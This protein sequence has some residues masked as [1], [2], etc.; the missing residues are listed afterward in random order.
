MLRPYQQKALD[1]IEGF[2]HF[3]DGREACLVACTSWG[4]SYIIAKLCEDYE[5]VV[6]LTNIT[7]LIYQTSDLLD[8]HGIAHSLLKANLKKEPKQESDNVILAMQQTLASRK[9]LV[10]K[11]DILVVDERHISFGSATMVEIENRLKPNKIIGLSATPMTS[12]GALLDGVELIDTVSIDELT[13]Q[14][15]LCPLDTY[16][17]RFSENLD[18]SDV[19]V[20]VNGDYNEVQL[21]EII[22]T[23]A[24]N[25]EVVNQWR[26][27][28]KDKKTIVFASGIAHAESLAQMFGAIT[29][30]GVVHSKK[31]DEENTKTMEQFRRGEIKVLC[32][33]NQLTTGFS[34]EDIEVGIICRPTKVRRL[35]AQMVGRVMR[36][37]ESKERGIIL[38]FGQC[39]SEFGLYNEVYE[40]PKSGDKI[41]L[42]Q[43]KDKSKLDGINVFLHEE[44]KQI[45]PITRREVVSTLQRIRTNAMT[46]K[47]AKS[48]IMLFEAS[49]DINEILS[50]AW[51]INEIKTSE[52][53]K[54]SSIDWVSDKWYGFVYG[55]SI[56]SEARNIRA[57]KTRAKNIVRDGKKLSSLYYFADWLLENERT[58]SW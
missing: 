24:Y 54:Q 15:F 10:P 45:A 12:S 42:Q 8:R 27:V 6:V 49:T 50:L 41:G 44:G 53:I 56:N 16:V 43:A 18:F 35:W 13:E 39:T 5:N 38:D 4:K 48:L 31:S 52:P 22:N 9:Q 33:M 17:A 55:G 14:G 32:S 47:D 36:T 25:T 11:C 40:P 29:T 1:L 28:C 20:G 37:H 30:S 34:E 21:S 7:K 26:S 58:Q 51:R 46:S 57:L 23:D 19:D 2:I 3:G